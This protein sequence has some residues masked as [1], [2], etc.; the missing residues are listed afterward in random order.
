M[1]GLTGLRIV[2]TRAAEQAGELAE[3]LR[4]AGAEA[5]LLPAIAILP[6]RDEARLRAAARSISQYDWLLL[7]SGNAAEAF[8]PLVDASSRRPKLAVVGNATQQ[9]SA[10]WGWTAALTPAEFTSDALA[11][12]F[13]DMPVAGLRFLMPSGDLAREVLPR[14]L[15][16]R[17]AMVDAVEAYLT[18][19]PEE[20]VA[21]ARELF[22]DQPALD[23]VTVASPSAVDNLIAVVGRAALEQVKIASIGPATSESVRGHGLN[24]EVEAREHTMAGLVW[25][26]ADHLR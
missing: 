3:L 25:S 17:G 12:A 7:T 11:A 26:M 14:R 24:V 20:S 18:V 1:G 21:R 8:L 13:E 10:R 19:M 23:W 5:I 6:A 2:V 16:A 9:R 22:K 15:R 4:A